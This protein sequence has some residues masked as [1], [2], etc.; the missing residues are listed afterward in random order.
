[1][2]PSTTNTEKSWTAAY[3][4]LPATEDRRLVH[5][6]GLGSG[7]VKNLTT[8]ITDSGKLR[9]A[10]I[11]ALQKSCSSSFAAASMTSRKTT[12]VGLADGSTASK[13]HAAAAVVT[14]VE[15]VTHETVAMLAAPGSPG[16]VESQ[17]PFLSASLILRDALGDLPEGEGDEL[18][19]S[20]P[21]YKKHTR[22]IALLRAAERV[23]ADRERAAKDD[24]KEAEKGLKEAT[25]NARKLIGGTKAEFA[26]AT[27]GMMPEQVC[28]WLVAELRDLSRLVPSDVGAAPAL[29][30]AGLGDLLDAVH[31]EVQRR[32]NCVVRGWEYASGKTHRAATLHPTRPFADAICVI[33]DATGG[34][35]EAAEDATFADW[36]KAFRAACDEGDAKHEG[37]LRER[38][39]AAALVEE[40]FL[41]HPTAAPDAATAS[42]VVAS[43]HRME[44]FCTA[45]AAIEIVEAAGSVALGGDFSPP[46]RSKAQDSAHASERFA[47]ALEALHRR[48]AEKIA[49]PALKEEINSSDGLLYVIHASR[50]SVSQGPARLELVK[51]GKSMLNKMRPR[52][53][54]KEI[55]SVMPR[56]SLFSDLRASQKTSDSEVGA[57]VGCDDLLLAHS[58]A[59]A[60]LGVEAYESRVRTWL[61]MALPKCVWVS[62]FPC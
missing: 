30:G 43:L 32:T 14:F 6:L 1:M 16:T 49:G 27:T 60:A 15:T 55:D 34:D 8:E 29:G 54:F 35:S 7:T 50:V 9:S 38:R 59:A 41:A 33:R 24:A 5:C 19:P 37:A 57:F 46:P 11:K 22:W 48:V 13:E 2:A 47:V 26:E 61:G 56:G 42:A 21:E 17:E 40:V 3:Q 44:S 12:V 45:K 58:R 53:R 18:A 39:C 10:L 20:E 51:V 4:E 28:A 36:D 52:D 62:L 23:A 25:D 31:A